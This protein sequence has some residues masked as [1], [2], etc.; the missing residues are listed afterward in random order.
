[1]AAW[2][3]AVR[4]WIKKGK[5]LEEDIDACKVKFISELKAAG[6]SEYESPELGKVSLQRKESVDYRGMM[7]SLGITEEQIEA[8]KPKFTTVSEEFVRAPQAWSGKVS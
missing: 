8:L 2:R 1:M 5:P 6:L 4:A 3:D 7:K